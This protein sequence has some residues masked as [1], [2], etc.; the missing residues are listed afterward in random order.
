[1]GRSVRTV[2]LVVVLVTAGCLLLVGCSKKDEAD[3]TRSSSTTVKASTSE[4]TASSGSTTE[5]DSG[6]G[7]PWTRDAQPYRGQDGTEHTIDCPADGS[8]DTVWGAGVYTDDSSICTAAVQSGL[9][10]FDEGGE[11]TIL[12]GPGQESFDSG[13][14]NG[15]ESEDYGPWEGSFTFP[16]AP[17][18]SVEFET[19]VSTWSRTLQSNAQDLG[20]DVTI[21]CSKNGRA[22]SV[23]GSGPFTTDSS[24]CTAGV[25]AGLITFEDGGT[26]V[27][28]IGGGQDSYS[29]STANG[30][31]TSEYGR[32]DSSFTFPEDLNEPVDAKKG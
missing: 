23:W 5:V 17:P 14:A 6:S 28:R 13:I 31:T 26:V 10:T 25:H 12:I 27:A 22:G 4:S 16:D 24:V 20:K 1:M 21:L 2:R 7:D 19:S 32:Y 9:I 3:T 11:V 30:V 18:G 8:P 15:V 29:G